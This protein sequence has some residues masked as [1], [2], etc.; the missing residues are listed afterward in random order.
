MSGLTVKGG[1]ELRARLAAVAS[2]QTRV[3]IARTW[4]QNATRGIRSDA[5]RR[6]GRGQASVRP[7][8]VSDRKAVVRGAYWLIFIDRGTKAHDI[9][10]KGVSGSGRGGRSNTKALKFEVGGKTVFARK[11]HRRRMPRK[12]FITKAAQDALREHPMSNEIVQAWNQRRRGRW[13]KSA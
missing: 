1:P 8:I 4:Q 13:T 9:R 11:V 3:D 12:P 5:P 6:T 7:G 2:S 10:P